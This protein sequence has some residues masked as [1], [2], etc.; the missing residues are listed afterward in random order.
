MTSSIC[1]TR[2]IEG[3]MH[4]LALPCARNDLHES[5]CER[6]MDFSIV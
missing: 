4:M 6:H 2:E 3:A 5:G 1:V